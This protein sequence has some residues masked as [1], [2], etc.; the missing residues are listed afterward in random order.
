MSA[1][2]TH[3]NLDEIIKANA[4]DCVERGVPFILPWRVPANK[5]HLD[6]GLDQCGCGFCPDDE[7][8]R[9]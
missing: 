1:A 8:R 7:Q 2:V 3:R 6:T 4:V 9:T 5:D